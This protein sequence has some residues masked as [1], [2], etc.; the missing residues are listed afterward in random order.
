MQ[1]L[2]KYIDELN[3]EFKVVVGGEF[4]KLDTGEIFKQIDVKKY[5][6]RKI[7]LY[8]AE[9]LSS[10]ISK[11]RELLGIT[12]DQRLINNRSK[13]PIKKK[14]ITKD[15]YEGGEF[16]IVYRNKLEELIAMN[17]SKNEKLVFFILRDFVVYP[18]NYIMING[19]IPRFTDLEHIVSLTERSIRGSLKTL[20]EK[21]IVKLVQ[22]GK[23]KAI[24]VNPEYYA[25]GK[26]L[27]VDTLNM[28]DLLEYD[29]EKVD[30]YIQNS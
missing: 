8:N 3:S 15:R 5:I 18:Y 7:E 21:G 24:Y 25:T 2:E 16:N 9:V 22:A 12:P 19:E 6:Q 23:R 28:F 4:V 26:N 13:K 14:D 20:E 17:L 10:N 27:N 29:H 30:S 1:T 11:S